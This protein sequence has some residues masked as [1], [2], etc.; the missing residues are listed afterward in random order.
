MSLL[1]IVEYEEGKIFVTIRDENEVDK[2]ESRYKKKGFVLC[3]REKA[4][5]SEGTLIT[6]YFE[7]RSKKKRR[8]KGGKRGWKTKCVWALQLVIYFFL[9]VVV[10]TILWFVINNLVDD[11]D[12]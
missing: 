2:V 10:A 5:D 12:K 6:L 11:M 7:K 9:L 1:N 4:E 8:P 3:E